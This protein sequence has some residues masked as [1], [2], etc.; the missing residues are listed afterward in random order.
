MQ[1]VFQDPKASLNPKM[2]IFKIL[3]EALVLNKRIAKEDYLEQAVKLLNL[4]DLRP[5]HIYRYPHEFSGSQQ[6]IY[7]IVTAREGVARE[8]IPR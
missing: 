6:Q 8:A 1:M 2:T 4:V 7:M 5:E 3:R